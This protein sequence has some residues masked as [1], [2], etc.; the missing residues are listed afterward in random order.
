MSRF[1]GAL[2]LVKTSGQPATQLSNRPPCFKKLD[3]K[4]QLAQR[5]HRRSFPRLP[6]HVNPAGK[7]VGNHRRLCASL[8]QWLLT[9]W[10]RRAQRSIRSHPIA[11]ARIRRF[12]QPSTAGFRLIAQKSFQISNG[13]RLA[14]VHLIE[15]SDTAF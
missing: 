13:H 8:Y 11:D 12:C 4:R 9:R 14:A 6:F 3:E 7:R 2:G 1:A 15:G 5:R 10:A